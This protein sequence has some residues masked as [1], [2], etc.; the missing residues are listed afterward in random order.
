MPSHALPRRLLLGPGPSNVHPRVLAAMAQPL[1]GH[2]DPE[3][4]AV[5]DEVQQGLRRVFGTHNPFTLPLSATGSAGMEACLSNLLEPGDDAVVGVAGVFGE[6]MCEV[7]TRIGARVTRVDAEWGT[8][9]RSDA[10]AAAIERA[11]PRLVAFVHA[12]TSTGVHQPVPDI[13]RVAREHGALVVLDCVTSLAGLPVCVDDWGVDAAY[14]GTQKCLSAPPGLSPVTLSE[15]ALARVRSRRSPVQSW[16]FD[17]T[18]LDG[19]YGVERVYHHTAPVSSVLALAEALR[20]VDEEGLEARFARHRE[21]ARGL[22]ST[23]A[24]L[25][26][27]P[28][29]E[30]RHSLPMLTS[31][32]L[33]DTATK[34]GEAEIRRRLLDRHGIEVGGGLGKLAGAIWRVGLMG[35]NARPESVEALREALEVELSTG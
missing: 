24:P 10:I 2:L 12:E 11:R 17:A 30:E 9:L 35:E 34:A 4:L 1:V 26:F 19:Y 23:L 13:A 16:Y 32:R 31:L 33:P 6:R 20:L 7:A 18:L 21:A 28:L 3:F 25:G 29:V 27:E 22:V 8:P 15:R 14:A 5:V